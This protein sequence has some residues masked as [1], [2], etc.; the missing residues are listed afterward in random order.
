MILSTPVGRK[1]SRRSWGAGGLR[2]L[3]TLADARHRGARVPASYVRH[4]LREAAGFASPESIRPPVHPSE[5][6]YPCCLPAL[7]R[8]TGYTP[9]EGLSSSLPNP[10]WRPHSPSP[11]PGPDRSYVFWRTEDSPS[12]LG[13]TLGKRVG[14]NPSR[15][16]ISYP[17][18]LRRPDPSGPAFGVSPRVIPRLPTA[19]AG[20][21]LFG[22]KTVQA[23]AGSLV[24]PALALCLVNV[25]RIRDSNS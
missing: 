2:R 7:G 16:R 3:R 20:L 1:G 25:R 24:G 9:H 11:P 17:P 23:R 5:P 6:A 12:G 8:F 4:D 19:P 15:V 18:H 22:L 21:V 10:P 13:R 14:G